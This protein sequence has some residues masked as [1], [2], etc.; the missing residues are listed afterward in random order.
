MHEAKP[1]PPKVT[2][3]FP[4]WNSSATVRGALSD[5]RA[6]TYPNLEIIVSDNHSDDGTTEILAEIAN[7]DS[8]VRHVVQPSNIGILPNFEFVAR[9]ADGELFAWAAA[10]DNWDPDFVSELVD[11]LEQHPK[12]AVAMPSVRTV[13][14]DRTAVETIRFARWAS[15]VG[16]PRWWAAAQ[17]MNLLPGP[18]THYDIY[19]M[20]RKAFLDQLLSRP[21]PRGRAGDRVLM[22]EAALGT[23]MVDSER[24][25]YQRTVRSQSLAVRYASDPLE[26]RGRIPQRSVAISSPWPTGCSPAL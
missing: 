26:R 17:M 22:C 5:L 9:E 16:K 1:S 12:A 15:L 20:W 14:A 23:F 7:S 6:Q 2:I 11:L 19:G 8:R 18:P 10:D 21:F 25:L 3:G 24:V 4:V 13:T